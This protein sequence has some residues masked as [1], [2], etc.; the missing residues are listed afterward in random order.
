MKSEKYKSK[1]HAMRHE[2][3]EGKKE[4]KMEYGKKRKR[5]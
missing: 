4:R 1:R 5:K 3:G 2:K